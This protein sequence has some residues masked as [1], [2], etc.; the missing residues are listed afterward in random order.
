MIATQ[1]APLASNATK[2]TA[3]ASVSRLSSGVSA[4]SA[5][6]GIGTS[7]AAEVVS[8]VIVTSPAPPVPSVKGSLASVRA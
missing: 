6:L 1:L 3:S 8:R 5:T 7:G 4:T 2:S